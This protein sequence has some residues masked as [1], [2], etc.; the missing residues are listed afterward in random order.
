MPVMITILVKTTIPVK[1]VFGTYKTGSLCINDWIRMSTR[2]WEKW[3]F[4]PTQDVGF[5]LCILSQNE[6]G[7]TILPTPIWANWLPVKV[8]INSISK[9]AQNNDNLNWECSYKF[10]LNTSLILSFLLFGHTCLIWSH[11][12][13]LVNWSCYF[14]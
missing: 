11:L 2:L 13:Y 14:N 12:P 10:M 8:V 6:T 7:A 4:L 3:E 5:N 1:T 9:T